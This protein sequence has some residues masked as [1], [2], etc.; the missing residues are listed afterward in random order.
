M[1]LVD[2]ESFEM[3]NSHKIAKSIVITPPIIKQKLS[4]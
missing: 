3:F 1:M 4:L 2:L